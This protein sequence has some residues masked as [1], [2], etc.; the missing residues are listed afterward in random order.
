MTITNSA[1][2]LSECFGNNSHC[3]ASFTQNDRPN[4]LNGSITTSGTGS[5]SFAS[6]LYLARALNI[7]GGSGALACAADLFINI[8]PVT[9][10][11]TFTS[12]VQA[13]NIALF[14]GIVNLA[15]NCTGVYAVQDLILL[16]GNPSTMYNDTVTGI[17]GVYAYQHEGR[18]IAAPHNAGN[19]APPS[20]AAYPVG[21]ADGTP[22]NHAE[23]YAS[24]FTP[25]SLNNKTL[26]ADKNFYANG[27]IFHPQTDTTLNLVLPDNCYFFCRSLQLY[28]CKYCFYLSVAAAGCVDNGGIQI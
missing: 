17:T 5:V 13:R 11:V 26:Q 20:L 14:N 22:I 21:M 24:S 16:N 3:D 8:A 1:V 18:T 28:V 15:G 19:T 4:Q 23:P 9:D 6:D 2:H 25:G 7:G 10:T 12:N 27:I